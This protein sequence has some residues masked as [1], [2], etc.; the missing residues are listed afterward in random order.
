M[1]ASDT[2]FSSRIV[3]QAL[4]PSMSHISSLKHLIDLQ[5]CRSSQSAARATSHGEFTA[6][7]A[8]FCCPVTGIPFNGT[9]RFMIL[10][11]N[12]FVVSEKAL[13]QVSHP[14]QCHWTLLHST[15]GPSLLSQSRTAICACAELVFM[16]AAATV[17]ELAGV[18][19]G[20]LNHL[21][22]VC[23]A[24]D[25]LAGAP[26]LSILRVRVKALKEFAACTALVWSTR[27]KCPSPALM[28]QSVAASPV[29]PC[30]HQITSAL[31]I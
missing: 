15:V 14:M 28:S 3:L 9:A 31:L 13:K 16:Q 18:P 26:M 21:I 8:E 11:K 10:P 27:R 5:L 24:A 2:A 6:N 17:S 20:P 7:D 1:L 25:E 29:S 12:G 30:R 23:P 22:P 4:P 19:V